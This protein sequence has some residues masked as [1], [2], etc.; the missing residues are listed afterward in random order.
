V[1]IANAI[2]A[3]SAAIPAI[4]IIA[5]SGGLNVWSLSSDASVMTGDVAKFAKVVVDAIAVVA[6]LVAT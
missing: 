2:I 4:Q 3:T 1:A 6:A 5:I